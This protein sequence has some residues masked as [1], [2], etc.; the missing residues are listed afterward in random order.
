[1]LFLMFLKLG[2]SCTSGNGIFYL[3]KGTEMRLAAPLRLNSLV[4]Y[5]HSIPNL[6]V[7]QGV[8]LVI[9]YFLGLKTWHI[10]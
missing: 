7:E 5:D 2:L 9:V 3:F 8:T 1:M 6:S 4:H 10:Q